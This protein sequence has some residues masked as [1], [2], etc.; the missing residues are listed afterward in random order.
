VDPVNSSSNNINSLA[1]IISPY[2]TWTTYTYWD[3]LYQR[4]FTQCTPSYSFTF[5]NYNYNLNYSREWNP[6]G[7]YINHIAVNVNGSYYTTINWTN[8]DNPINPRTVTS[9][10][11]S[12]NGQ[13]M[14]LAVNLHE[15]YI[16]MSTHSEPVTVRVALVDGH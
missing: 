3:P 1:K 11:F 2:Y 6:N 7:G 10:W 4:W 12:V 14:N 8:D 5:S 15:F 16:P 13:S 9:V